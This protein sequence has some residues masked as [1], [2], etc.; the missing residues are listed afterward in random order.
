MTVSTIDGTL[1]SVNVKRKY[2]KL[3]RLSD[4]VFRKADGSQDVL[5][6]QTIVTPEIG[7]AL[8]PGVAGRFYIYKA[9]DHKGIHAVRSPDGAVLMQF[10]KT[11]ETLMMILFLVNVVWVTLMVVV[12][13]G[14]PL[15]GVA[16]IVFSAVLYLLY[17]GT[18]VQAE[19]QVNADRRVPP[20]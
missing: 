6:G 14:L 15:L 20:A 7:A 17:R 3:W 9:L 16:L 13:E 8:Q 10:P 1:E 12:R 19:A 2:A 11:N 5:D 4:L 18:R